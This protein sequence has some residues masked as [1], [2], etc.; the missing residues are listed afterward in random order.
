MR[1]ATAVVTTIVRKIHFHTHTGLESHVVG[2]LCNKERGV[3]NFPL[4]GKHFLPVRAVGHTTITTAC[5]SFNI[6]QLP[7]YSRELHASKKSSLIM[8]AADGLSIMT[9]PT[10]PVKVAMAIRSR[11]MVMPLEERNFSGGTKRRSA[12]SSADTRSICRRNLSEL[13]VKITLC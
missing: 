3:K 12:F 1:P 13:V 5:L 10:C 4:P 9:P 11:K 2:S 6:Q 7:L 8:R